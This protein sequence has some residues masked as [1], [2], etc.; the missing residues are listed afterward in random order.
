VTALAQIQIKEPRLPP[1]DDYRHNDWLG[2]FEIPF[3]EWADQMIDWI[4]VNL[5]DS[6]TAKI[7]LLRWIAKP[8][9]VLLELVVEVFFTRV[10]WLWIV[11]GIGL[12][13]W[14]LR[15]P[16]V[17]SMSA[18]GLIVCGLLGDDYWIETAHTLGVMTV[19]LSLCAL[20]GIPLGVACARSDPLWRVMRVVLDAMQVVHPFVYLLPFL[21]FFGLGNTGATLVTLIYSMPG[22]VRI[23]NLGVR[24]LPQDVIEA[25]RAFGASRWQ[26]TRDIYVPLAQPA[27]LAGI[28]QTLILA[29]SMHA[30]AALLGGGGLGKLLFRG[31][32]SVGMPQVVASGAAFV[33]VALILDRLTQP[34]SPRRVRVADGTIPIPPTD[35][36]NKWATVAGVAGVTMVVAT[37]FM[38]WSTSGSRVSSHTRAADIDLAGR[39]FDGLAASGGSCFGLVVLLCGAATVVIS[40]ANLGRAEVHTRWLS[41]D[42]AVVFAAAALSTAGA[43]A[44]LS[45]H[46]AVANVDTGVGLFI[47]LAAA[48]VCLV[49]SANWV[50]QSPF[51]SDAARR[52]GWWRVATAGWGFAI[53]LVGGLS[54]WTF[55]AREEPVITAEVQAQLDRLLEL[56]ADPATAAKASSDFMT[57]MAQI[58]FVEPLVHDGFTSRGTGLGWIVLAAGIGALVT[59]AAA[60]RAR[61]DRSHQSLSIASL[62]F[63]VAAAAVS[64][65]WIASLVR[66]HDQRIVVGVGAFL[67]LVGGLMMAGASHRPV[68]GHHRSRIALADLLRVEKSASARNVP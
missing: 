58:D 62:A 59:L 11:I 25:G 51:T 55:D 22:L 17:G 52:G 31:L 9:D 49:A 56:A 66:V 8:V 61:G 4:D 19:T 30:I 20:I 36:E 16:L 34:R 18:L 13:G 29:L 63:A 44:F 53:L 37:A 32:T 35:E 12:I 67:A 14:R 3:G 2:Q 68:A 50:R 33:I 45:P 24:E 43:Y 57:L 1:P 42:S 54:G 27:I 46:E 41:P 15:G 48:I 40:A 65:A 28:N 23:T 5:G 7:P 10:S 6:D 64:T 21:F 47:A 60:L 38:P 26:M 39:S